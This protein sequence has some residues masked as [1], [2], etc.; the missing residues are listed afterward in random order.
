MKQPISRHLTSVDACRG[1]AALS[2][3][4]FHVFVWLMWPTEGFSI[5][6][7]RLAD[8]ISGHSFMENA[9]S[10]TLGLGFLGVQLFFVISGFCIHA[11]YVNSDRLDR[12]R[13]FVRRLV[14]IY[15]L[16][17][18]LVIF[19]FLLYGIMEGGGGKHGVTLENFIGHLFFWHYAGPEGAHGL[20]ITEVLWTIAIEVQFYIVYAVV[21]FNL[22]GR[23]G[24]GRVALVWL[25]ADIGYRIFWYSAGHRMGLP[26]ALNPDRLAIMR[27]GEWLL[28]A[29]LAEQVFKKGKEFAAGGP[30]PPV[31][32]AIGVCVILMGVILGGVFE[33]GA[34][35]MD[36]PGAIGFYFIIRG[37]IRSEARGTLL[38]GR[39]HR[40]L[41][42]L[43][44]RCYTLYLTHLTVVAICA[45]IMQRLANH[46][47]W[48]YWP[49]FGFLSVL[50]AVIA[51]VGAIAVAL[52]VY[53][54]IELPSHQLARK[55][56][57]RKR[58][59]MEPREIVKGEVA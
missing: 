15:P 5:F 18:A 41:G 29:W 33:F 21:G 27:F 19:L 4:L 54:F 55:L 20:G 50:M 2:V 22:I 32:F 34:D 13:Y 56:C 12:K 38:T 58:T 42:F 16:Y 35:I 30:R 52:P 51:V 1:G 37:L 31:D 3:L 9:G 48:I 53:K 7:G 39:I 10:L 25:S 57:P 8:Q 43:G 28:G 17:F 47:D 24:A 46:F 14:R 59:K 11:A 44:D 6:D 23:F 49:E 26:L 36:V 45:G 40:G